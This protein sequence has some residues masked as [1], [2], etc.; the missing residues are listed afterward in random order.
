[1]LKVKKYQLVY[2]F[3]DLMDDDPMSKYPANSIQDM[4]QYKRDG[5]AA[6]KED[7]MDGYKTC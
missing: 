1:M 2:S 3:R 5:H 6:K 7:A 4:M